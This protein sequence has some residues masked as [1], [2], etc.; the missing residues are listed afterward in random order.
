MMYVRN[1]NFSLCI[2]TS[3]QLAIWSSI[4]ILF[5]VIVVIELYTTI[6]AF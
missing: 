1:I 4:Y 3:L 2:I 5:Y 6:F